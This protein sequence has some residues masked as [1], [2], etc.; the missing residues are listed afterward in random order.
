L[1]QSEDHPSTGANGGVQEDGVERW[2]SGG[3]RHGT[4]WKREA[5][6]IGTR[7]L[8]VGFTAIMSLA[9][10]NFGDIV[11]L[12]GSFSNSAI[13]FI[14]PMLFFIKLVLKHPERSERSWANH[15][16]TKW[17]TRNKEAILPYTIIVLGVIASIIGVTTTIQGMIDPPKDE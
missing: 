7:V 11:S 2:P 16:S 6:K 3:E 5:A 12:V 14:L 9:F 17:I 15:A 1:S 4:N 13:A 10:K 8:L